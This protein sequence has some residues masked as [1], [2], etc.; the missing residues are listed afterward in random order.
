MD[1][2]SV[3]LLKFLAGRLMNSVCSYAFHLSL[4]IYIYIYIYIYVEI[5]T[6]SIVSWLVKSHIGY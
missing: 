4:N 3:N 5:F 1:T 2:D 6:C